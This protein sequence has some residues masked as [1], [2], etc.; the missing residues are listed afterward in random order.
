MLE[1]KDRAALE[2]AWIIARRD[3]DRAEQ[4]DG[5]LKSEKSWFKVATFAAGSVQ[6]K[7]LRLKV[8]QLPP[9]ECWEHDP[10]E[11]DKD[12]QRL[13]R[14]MLAAGLSRFEPDPLAALAARTDP[15]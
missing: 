2:Q 12:G 11:R 9:C 8:W 5:M 7:T 6:H 15:K 1:P 13:L 10:D 4:L 3:P 14:R